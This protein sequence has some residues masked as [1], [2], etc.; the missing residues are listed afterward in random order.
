MLTNTVKR[1]FCMLFLR[2][3]CV[4]KR[5]CNPVSSFIIGIW[6][7]RKF[8]N[9]LKHVPLLSVFFFL[10]ASSAAYCVYNLMNKISVLV[11]N[12]SRATEIR[13][14][15]TWSYCRFWPKTWQEDTMCSLFW[16]EMFL[17]LIYTCFFLF[18]IISIHSVLFCKIPTQ[19]SHNFNK[20]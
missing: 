8:C 17:F 13:V 15:P 14:Q 4:S 1:V 7:F 2:P 9:L 6:C 11:F 12:L 20:V 10:P 18:L 19:R 3:L 16:E 5:L